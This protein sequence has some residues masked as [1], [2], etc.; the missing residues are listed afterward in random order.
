MKFLDR[1]QWLYLGNV[2]M[3]RWVNSG[4]DITAYDPKNILCIKWDEIGDMATCLH[5]F[6]LLRKRYP[7]AEIDVITKPYSAPLLFGNGDINNVY[8]DLKKWNKKYD[9]LVE[10]RG[11][12]S[13][14]WK[15]LRYYP[16]VRLD[17]GI[18]RLRHRGNQLHETQTNFEIIK[19]ILN[20]LPFEKP[21][22]KIPE[23]SKSEV[24]Y[25]ISQNKLG[26]YAIIHAGARRE[27]RR[28]S[29]QKFAELC[30]WLHDSKGLQLV[31][32]GIEEEEKQISE[33]TDKLT[34]NY[35]LFTKNHDL[36]CLAAL[37]QKAQIFI[38][39][40]SGPLQIADVVGTPLIGLFGPGVPNVFYPQGEN[41]KIVHHVL[42]CNPCDQ[43]HCVRPT[44]TCMDKIELAEVKLLV[45]QILATTGS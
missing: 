24:D 37:M 6:S 34:C 23:K 40:E 41:S 38:G 31:F 14:L 15:T 17:R 5:V 2:I 35:V 10:L 29:A 30:Q 44:D 39:N 12:R 16:K 21:Q 22:L 8:T 13:T 43:L 25:F 36:M 45:D 18:V 4:K 11:T 1:E 7:N 9:I 42:D 3:S 20:D 19:P 26:K 32:A 28:W 27:L 33:I